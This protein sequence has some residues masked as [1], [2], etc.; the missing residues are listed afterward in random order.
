MTELDGWKVRGKKQFFRSSSVKHGLAKL[1]IFYFPSRD[2]P[3][4]KPQ[5]SAAHEI[6]KIIESPLSYSVRLKSFEKA[7]HPKSSHPVEIVNAHGLNGSTK[8]LLIAIKV[9]TNLKNQFRILIVNSSQQFMKKLHLGCA[10]VCIHIK[11]GCVSPMIIVSILHHAEFGPNDH[12]EDA[13][14]FIF[15]ELRWKYLNDIF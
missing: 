10:S 8:T 1:L 3:L 12:R 4:S 7:R 15:C 9:R 2:R 5:G 13:P 14:H 6:Q 11:V